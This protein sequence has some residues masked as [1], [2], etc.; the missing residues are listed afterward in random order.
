MKPKLALQ[1]YTVREILKEEDF[2]GTLEKIAAIGYAGIETAF[3]DEKTGPAQAAKIFEALGL[4]VPSAHCE[5]PLGEQKNAVLDL[6][7]TFGCRRMIWHGWPRDDNYNSIEGVKR[8]ADRYNEANAVAKASGLSFGLHNHWWEFE[9]IEEGYPYQVL[10]ERLEPDIF[11]EVDTYW[12]KTAGLDP[13]KIVAELGQRAPFLH[14]KDGPAVKGE[15]MVAVGEGTQDIPAIAEAAGGATEWL[16]VELDACATDML[17]A[18][19]KSY[20]YLTENN[21]A[22]GKRGA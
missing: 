4:T 9:P 21:L 13:V 17:E 2:A 19:E 18:V 5:L 14:I 11:F 22:L 15:P 12:V 8:L 1:L 10:L 20:Q 7:N 6:V 16:V 3:F